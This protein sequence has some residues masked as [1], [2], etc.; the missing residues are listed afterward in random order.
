MVSVHT[1]SPP[2]AHAACLRCLCDCSNSSWSIARLKAYLRKKED[3]VVCWLRKPSFLNA[4]Y[5]SIVISHTHCVTCTPGAFPSAET[6]KQ[7]SLLTQTSPAFQPLPIAFCH[8]PIVSGLSIWPRR[9]RRQTY[10]F[11][12]LNMLRTLI[13]DP[14]GR[15]ENTDG[16]A[17]ASG[18]CLA[19]IGFKEPVV[20]ES[21]GSY[22]IRHEHESE[23]FSQ[24]GRAQCIRP[25]L[26]G[27]GSVTS[28]PD[29]WQV[30][31]AS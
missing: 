8:V 15:K 17:P 12:Y 23:N 20:E 5:L 31:S 9:R 26:W 1:L 25:C 24:G 22:I 30:I 3:T 4:R 6:N 2:T 19:L 27:R 10:R 11:P 7:K 28:Q 29:E 21:T 14:C 13:W 16:T 18:K